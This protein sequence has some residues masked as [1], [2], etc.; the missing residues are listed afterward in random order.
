MDSIAILN[1]LQENNSL[2]REHHVRRIGLFGSHIRSE[3]VSSSDIDL[4]VEFDDRAFGENFKGYFETY[5]SLYIGLQDIF[6]DNIDLVTVDMLSPSIAP[7]VFK[8]VRFIEE[9]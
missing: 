8:E 5:T 1:K 7:A 4:L 3:Q 9:L 2:L 6:E